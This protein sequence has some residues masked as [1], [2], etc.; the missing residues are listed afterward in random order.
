MRTELDHLEDLIMRIDQFGV[1]AYDFRDLT[2]LFLAV[3]VSG[4][5]LAP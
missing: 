2:Y 3:Q 4:I 5:S 1:P